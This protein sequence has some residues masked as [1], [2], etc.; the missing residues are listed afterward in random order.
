MSLAFFIIWFPI[1]IVAAYIFFSIRPIEPDQNA[2]IYF[3]EKPWYTVGPGG[4]AFVPPIF[5]TMDIYPSKVIQMEIPGEPEE[6]QKSDQDNIQA[7][8]VAPI[9]IPQP[10]AETAVWYKDD[11][12]CITWSEYK[13]QFKDQKDV[14]ESLVNDPL[15]ARITSEPSGILRFK[16]PK[17]KLFQFKQT[18]GSMEEARRQLSDGFVQTLQSFLA[19]V[20]VDHANKITPIINN[21]LKLNLQKHVG[22]NPDSPDAWGIKII[23]ASLKIIDPGEH[24]NIAIAEAASAQST[25]KKTIELAEGEAQKVR[26]TADADAYRQE[27]MGTAEAARITSVAKAMS[28]ENA[29]F[30]AILEITEKSVESAKFIIAPEIGGLVATVA[31]IVKGSTAI[32][33]SLK[34]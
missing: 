1:W 20:T 31:Q 34:K 10:P 16:L 8:K 28:D 30:A 23:E 24:V 14:M 13:E 6:I 25:R 2:A 17:E 12:K 21:A 22:L 9:R 29:R 18:I 11:G 19:R 3:W 4:F 7:G 15:N 26:L 32:Q 33:D 27:K 5:S